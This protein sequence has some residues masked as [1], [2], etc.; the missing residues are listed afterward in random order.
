MYIPCSLA[1]GF[2]DIDTSELQMIN[3][4][5]FLEV[6]LNLKITAREH[7]VTTVTP[8]DDLKRSFALTSG[9]IYYE[10]HARTWSSDSRPVYFQRMLVATSDCDLKF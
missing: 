8:D 9:G 2:A 7:V 3:I 1:P 4:R 5:P 6:H 10:I